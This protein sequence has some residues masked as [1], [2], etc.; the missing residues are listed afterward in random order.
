MVACALEYSLKQL[1]RR[2][3]G[4]PAS[5]IKTSN[6][7]WYYHW[8]GFRKVKLTW[9]GTCSAQKYSTTMRY[10]RRVERRGSKTAKKPS[11]C[12][13]WSCDLVFE[14]KRNQESV[15]LSLWSKRENTGTMAR[16]GSP[17]WSIPWHMLLVLNSSTSSEQEVYGSIDLNSLSNNLMGI[18]RPKPWTSLKRVFALPKRLIL[19]ASWRGSWIP[20]LVKK[21]IPTTCTW[22]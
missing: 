16:R 21:S 22:R 12:A 5:R 7:A 13:V 18:W 6:S 19:L 2:S 15:V 10:G 1:S 11:L 3:Y 17:E 4:S 8:S 14:K 20:Q 9:D